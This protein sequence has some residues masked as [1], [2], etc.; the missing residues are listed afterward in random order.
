MQSH[1]KHSTAKHNKPKHSNMHTHRVISPHIHCDRHIRSIYVY[2]YLY[3]HH[4]KNEWLLIESFSSRFFLYLWKSVQK[5][6]AYEERDR[7]Q[8]YWTLCDFYFNFS[9][10]FSSFLLFF[11]SVCARSRARCMLSRAYV[12]TMEHSF[13]PLESVIFARCL[14]K[15]PIKYHMNCV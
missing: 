13:L 10:Q 5:K 12:G 9:R 6:A 7:I 3:T 15:F 1:P 14:R 4:R 2:I 8:C 11:A